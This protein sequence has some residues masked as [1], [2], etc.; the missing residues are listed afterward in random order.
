MTRS[1][2]NGNHRSPFGAWLRVQADLESRAAGLS[3]IDIDWCLHQ[4]SSRPDGRNVQNVMFIEEKRF[5][6]PLKN[7]QSDTLA[8][9]YQLF[10]NPRMKVMSKRVRSKMAGGF[11]RVRFFGVHLLSFSGAGP[12]DSEWI[13]W[14]RKR[15]TIDQLKGILRFDTNP[16]HLG[17]RDERCHHGGGK[18][19]PMF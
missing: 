13:E 10:A 11:V 16:F 18:Q 2:R 15:I 17:R 12:D 1:C 6:E 5:A 9:I 8:V 19:I 3:I 7:H 4:Y 14:D